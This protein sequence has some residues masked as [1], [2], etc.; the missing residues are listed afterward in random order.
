MEERPNM[1]RWL[2]LGAAILLFV[3]YGW[4]AITGKTTTSELQADH[5]YVDFRVEPERRVPEET[6]AID[7]P[8]FHADLTTVGAALRHL[9]IT[10]PKYQQDSEGKK[11]DLAKDLQDWHLPLRTVL[12]APPVVK[13]DG[14]DQLRYTDFD[15]K[16]TKPNA[17]TCVFSYE[18][19]GVSLTKTIA[20]TER[21]FELTV[22]LVVTNKAKEA[23]SHRLTI[24]SDEWHA[25]SET[26]SSFAK[27]QSEWETKSEAYGDS[28]LQ[29]L[30]D[31]DFEP[32]K[33]DDEEVTAEK[34]RRA[35]GDGR[36]AAVS[37]SYFSK[38]ILPLASPATP[39]AEGFVEEYFRPKEFLQKDKDPLYGHTYRARLNYG[40]RSLAPGET[41][42]YEM[43]AF[44]G[45]KEREVLANV[46]GGKF[47]TTE[48]L[49]LGYFGSIGKV[50]IRYLYLLFSV[51]RSWGWAIVLLTITVKLL[52]FPLSIAQIKS[53]MAMR[54][55]KPEMDALNAKYKDDA[56]QRGL[57]LQELWRKNKVANPMLGCL[58]VLLQMPVWWALYSALQ[59]AVELYHTPF[60]PFI[61]DLSA[62][63]KYFIIPALLGASSWLQQHLMPMQGDPAQQKMMKY[64]MP[65]IFTVM[66]LFLPAGLGI[67]FL[68]NTWLGILQQIAVERYYQ[69]K[70]TSDEPTPVD[71]SKA[72]GKGKGRVEQRG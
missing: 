20:A 45:P 14:A 68:T 11:I 61:P 59:T 41:A 9:Y 21:P 64:M 50:L 23:R 28:K 31:G 22:N 43:L 44:A 29:R 15:W 40:V 67:Y 33:L 39:A 34:W 69:S 54:K 30:T 58:P 51:V 53:T 4:P 52:L 48:L 13:A 2:L 66:M 35:P 63:G 5:G 17:T 46:G 70:K 36:M 38:A 18:D 55:L 10:D 7:G 6:C 72:F 65:A 12:R 32:K 57:A 26:K 1:T 56:Q 60:G 71:D 3:M 42:V 62:P 47:P 24:E 8:H 19:D 16:V 25:W 49:N 27:R 37:S